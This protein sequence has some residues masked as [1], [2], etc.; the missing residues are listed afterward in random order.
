M[1]KAN[2]LERIS[3]DAGINRKASRDRDQFILVRY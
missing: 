2:L 1:N 3:K